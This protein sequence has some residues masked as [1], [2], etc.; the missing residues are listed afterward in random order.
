MPHLTN[1]T[2]ALFTTIQ[3]RSISTFDLHTVHHAM[4]HQQRLIGSCGLPMPPSFLYFAWMYMSIKDSLEE[5]EVVE[6]SM[7]VVEAEIGHCIG[8]CSSGSILGGWKWKLIEK[9][10]V[11]AYGNFHDLLPAPTSFYQLPCISTSFHG[12]IC[13][14]VVFGFSSQRSPRRTP[15]A[16]TI[17]EPYP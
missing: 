13:G 4:E 12:I 10:E 8:N 5:L 11:E 3:T 2:P 16:L 6:A 15:L 14:F 17:T 9:T 7:E 1:S